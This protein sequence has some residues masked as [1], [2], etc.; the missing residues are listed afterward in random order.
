MFLIPILFEKKKRKEKKRKE[1]NR[2]VKH[3]AVDG[4]SIENQ[5]SL[6]TSGID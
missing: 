5:K 2:T 4:V 1:K 3:W 6:L